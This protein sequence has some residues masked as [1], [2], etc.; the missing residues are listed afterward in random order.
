MYHH[1]QDTFVQV[2]DAGSFSKAGE[3][4]FISPTAVMKQIDR[5]EEALEV[6]PVLSPYRACA[7]H[8]FYGWS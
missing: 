4:L 1:Q 6:R 5:L 8:P 7:S 2:A 3:A